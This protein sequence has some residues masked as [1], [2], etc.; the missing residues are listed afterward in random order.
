MQ[1]GGKREGPIETYPKFWNPNSLTANGQEILRI[2]SRKKS[3]ELV[4][5]ELEATLEREILPATIPEFPTVRRMTLGM[6][7][8]LVV[9]S[10]FARAA[11]ERQQGEFTDGWAPLFI[12]YTAA[13]FFHTC[14]VKINSWT[15]QANK[16]RGSMPPKFEVQEILRRLDQAN[17]EN[18]LPIW[19]DGRMIVQEGHIAL[20]DEKKFATKKYRAPYVLEQVEMRQEG[21][22]LD[23]AGSLYVALTEYNK[24]DPATTSPLSVGT[25]EDKRS[26]P[27]EDRLMKILERK[28]AESEEESMDETLSETR[29]EIE[30]GNTP[31]PKPAE[32]DFTAQDLLKDLSGYDWADT[33][34]PPLTSSPRKNLESPLTNETSNIGMILL[35]TEESKKNTFE[36]KKNMFLETLDEKAWREFLGELNQGTKSE[37]TLDDFKEELWDTV[38]KFGKP[39]LMGT[40]SDE[41]ARKKLLNKMVK[42]R[43][44]RDRRP[45]MTNVKTAVL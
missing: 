2:P 39:V 8:S 27:V 21:K 14:D 20:K 42:L 1:D 44:R 10:L 22:E 41:N 6:N 23:T 25:P 11:V 32:E 37:I 15:T 29:G 38:V 28:R 30:V 18:M 43:E 40:G 7:N 17:L 24:Q 13:V 5:K 4:K 35:S 9:P 3:F 34:T 45:E 36:G 19:D 33:A 12:G 16:M 26:G 31:E